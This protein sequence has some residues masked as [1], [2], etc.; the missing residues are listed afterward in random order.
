MRKKQSLICRVALQIR[1][2]HAI[3]SNDPCC[4]FYCALA[5]CGFGSSLRGIISARSEVL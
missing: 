2:F 5:G 3:A 4:I 1:D